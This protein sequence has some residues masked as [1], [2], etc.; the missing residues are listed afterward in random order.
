MDITYYFTKDNAS[1]YVFDNY[2]SAVNA[3]DGAYTQLNNV[4]GTISEAKGTDTDMKCVISIKDSV[5]LKKGDKFTVNFA[6]HPQDWSD[7]NIKNDYSYKNA[8]GVVVKQ[9]G[10]VVIGKEP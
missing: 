8:D 2:H 9:N 5:S 6:I 4:T 10:K 1:T 7:I 3:Y